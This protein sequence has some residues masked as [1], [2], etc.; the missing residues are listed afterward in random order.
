MKVISIM[1][2]VLSGVIFGIFSE[3]FMEFIFLMIGAIIFSISCQL[4]KFI[5]YK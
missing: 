2:G 5:S 1:L 3:T 4:E